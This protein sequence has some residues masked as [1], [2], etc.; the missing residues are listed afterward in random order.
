[1]DSDDFLDGMRGE[2]PFRE[3]NLWSA[4]ETPRCP[5]SRSI[6]I[7]EVGL[8]FARGWKKIP[9][10][11]PSGLWITSPEDGDDPSLI[12]GSVKYSM[13]SDIAK[14]EGGI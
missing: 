14:G 2:L 4:C 9:A 5:L 7:L 1:M 10:G 12:V 8:F 3:P 13:F 11:C 6:G